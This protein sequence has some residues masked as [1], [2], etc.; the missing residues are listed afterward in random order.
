MQQLQFDFGPDE[1]E[2]R[3]RYLELRRQGITNAIARAQLGIPRATARAWD[4]SSPVHLPHTRL[5]ETELAKI[6]KALLVDGLPYREAASVAG[7]S[8]AA[9]G[10]RAISWRDLD[11]REEEVRF[12]NQSRVCKVHGR[13]KVW[14]CVAC[15]ATAHRGQSQRSRQ[16]E[17]QSV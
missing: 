2:L 14:P 8:R 5:R 9:V 13:V 6:R 12:Q 3:L 10:R 15:A 16:D 11:E 17:L 4:K 1:E 7:V